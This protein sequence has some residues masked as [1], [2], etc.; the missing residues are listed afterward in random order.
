MMT[1]VVVLQIDSAEVLCLLVAEAGHRQKNDLV[2]S[3]PH[4]R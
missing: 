1:V 4:N 2:L 3:C